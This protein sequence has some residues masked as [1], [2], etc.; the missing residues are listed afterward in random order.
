M[1]KRILSV[2]LV[3]ALA[4]GGYLLPKY[5][6]T[7]EDGEYRQTPLD[8]DAVSIQSEGLSD[9]AFSRRLCLLSDLIQGGLT[10]AASYPLTDDRARAQWEICCRELDALARQGLLPPDLVEDWKTLGDPPGEYALQCDVSSYVCFDA[11]QQEAVSFVVIEL[12][13]SLGSVVLEPSREKILCLTL[14]EKSA[15]RMDVWVRENPV[16]P[17][18]DFL[19]YLGLTENAE[20]YYPDRLADFM[21]KADEY[22]ASVIDWGAAVLPGTEE[23]AIAYVY[24][25]DSGIASFFPLC[26]GPMEYT[27]FGYSGNP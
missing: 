20:D 11:Q 17:V 2:I 18:Q 10:E 3:I 8:R 21:L 27:A 5:F 15:D 24:Q 22:G 4:A 26:C 12:W 1:M 25:A 7:R 9:G 13:D 6:L 14:T 16:L 19:S 23:L